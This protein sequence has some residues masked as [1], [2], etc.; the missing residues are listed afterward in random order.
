MVLPDVPVE[1]TIL[2]FNLNSFEENI[3]EFDFYIGLLGTAFVVYFGI[4]R[5]FKD[6]FREYAQF[7]L[8]VFFVLFLS[9]DSNYWLI[10]DSE[11]P[12][13]G[14]ERVSARMIAVP[15][16]F[17]IILAVIFFQKWLNEHYHRLPVLAASGIFLI[18]LASDLWENLKLWRISDRDNYFQPIPVDL[19]G[20]IAANHLD[21]LYYTVIGIGLGITI[22][23]AVFLIFMSWREHRLE[24]KYLKQ[25]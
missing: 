14:S 1:S 7:I 15:I 9:M 25:I 18:F 3:W 19:S 22:L 2:P 20:S 21:P 24:R 10:R 6:N 17:L 4:Y 11:I 23:V 12:L 5:W 8:P 16:T 13:F